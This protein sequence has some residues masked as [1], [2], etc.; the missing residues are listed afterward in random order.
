[1]ANL[2]WL[3]TGSCSGDT[4]SLLTADG[5][6]I[7]SLIRSGAIELLWH[8]SLTNAPSGH[9]ARLIAAIEAGEQALDILCIEGSLITGPVGTGMFDA[10][11]GRP[12]I[13]IVASLAAQAQHVVAMGTCATFGGIPAAPPNP[14][15]CTGLQFDRALPGGLLP[16][17]WRSR[18]GQPVINLAGCPVHPLTITRCL[19]MLA[20][21]LPLELD[22]LNRPTAFFSSTVHQGCTRNEYHEYDMEDHQ[23]GER[24][25][26]YFNLGCQGPMT[27]ANCNSALWNGRSSKTRAGV[28]C[29]GCTSPDFPRDVDLFK[30]EK[31]GAVPVN[32]PLGVARAHYMAYKNLA[33][34]AAPDRLKDR[35]MEP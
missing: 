4:M 8:P 31:I 10:Y 5:P 2:L 7:E 24:G 26:L 22:F 23:L 19:A 1:M 18:S 35:E 17:D 14:T 28:P 27:L 29:F 34:K 6:S 9:L 20:A 32:L 30:T 16:A 15:D 11:K 13:E 25:C 3:Q 12:K 21:G 33:L